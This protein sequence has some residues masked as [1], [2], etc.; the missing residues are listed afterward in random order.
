MRDSLP[1]WGPDGY[2]YP[3]VIEGGV[4]EASDPPAGTDQPADDIAHIINHFRFNRTV[5]F[6]V[7][8]IYIILERRVTDREVFQEMEDSTSIRKVRRMSLVIRDVASYRGV[9]YIAGKLLK[10]ST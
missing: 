6:E 9:P 7:P 5:S 8:N 10:I 1:G 2:S 4:G 3:S